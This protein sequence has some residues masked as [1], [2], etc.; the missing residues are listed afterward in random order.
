MYLANLAVNLSVSVLFSLLI[1]LFLR[2]KYRRYS[3]GGRLFSAAFISGVAAVFF[4]GLLQLLRPEHGS[5]AGI[6]FLLIDAFFFAGFTEEGS[7]FIAVKILFSGK[8]FETPKETAVLAASCGAGFALIENIMYSF[9]PASIV[10]LRMFFA[11]PV[12][13]FSAL[14]IGYYS[15]YGF[16]KSL[17]GF[18][19]ALLFHGTYDLLI[20]LNLAVSFLVF[21]LIVSAAL[22]SLF[23]CGKNGAKE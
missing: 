11:F 18:A 9:D 20:S 2:K 19:M 5:G 21:P 1:L 3:P 13:I 16:K 10:V 14:F 4:A 12:H 15:F 22:L 23:I 6:F 17:K 7:K 8:N